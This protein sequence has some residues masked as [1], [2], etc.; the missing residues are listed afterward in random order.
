[1]AKRI[2]GIAFSAANFLIAVSYAFPTSP[3]A[4]EEG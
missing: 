4:F 2:S 1:L 3:N